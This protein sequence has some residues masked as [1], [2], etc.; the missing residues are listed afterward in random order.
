MMTK[1]KRDRLRKLFLKLVPQAKKHIKVF[2]PKKSRVNTLGVLPDSGKFSTERFAHHEGFIL[3]CEI[4]V[5]QGENKIQLWEVHFDSADDSKWWCEL[6]DT[7]NNP[8]KKL[9]DYVKNNVDSI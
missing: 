7:Y 4:V 5:P 8:T 2:N 9:Y 3:A 1:K 6:A